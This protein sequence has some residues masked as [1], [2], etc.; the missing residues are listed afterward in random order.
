DRSTGLLFGS[1]SMRSP[2]LHA[3]MTAWRRR[4]P[5]RDPATSAATFCSSMTFQR[6]NSI[7]SG[8]SRSRHTIL[9]ARRVVPPDLIAPAAR[10]PI[11]RN[12][13]RPDVLPPRDRPP[14]P[15]GSLEKFVPEPE[16]YLKMRASR[17]HRSM[18]P[19]SFTRSSFTDWMKQLWTTT[20]FDRY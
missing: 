17:V 2:T 13:M 14:F 19:P 1:A 15:P 3:A 9:A 7:T 20:L 18:I 4:L 6:M 11:L 10:S 5:N 16:P 12:D 8:W